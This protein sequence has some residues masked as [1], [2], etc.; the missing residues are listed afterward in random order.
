MLGYVRALVGI[1]RVAPGEDL[2]S[3]LIAIRDGE[4][5]LNEDE[6]TSMARLLLIAG[7]ETTV[8]LIGNGVFTLLHHP[9]QLA[10][11]HQEPTRIGE[12]VEEIVR[13]EPPGQTALPR[14]A[15]ER[16]E[17]AGVTTAPGDTVLVAATTAPSPFGRRWGRPLSADIIGEVAC[18]GPP[19][20]STRTT[21]DQP[22]QNNCGLL[23]PSGN[24]IS[25]GKSSTTA[26][27]RLITASKKHEPR[28]RPSKVSGRMSETTGRR[29][30]RPT[31]DRCHEA[32]ACRRST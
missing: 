24:R 6:L 15:A 1:K 19:T 2:L 11:L 26:T 4:D 30:P 29:S 18:G 14:Y 31:V 9:A 21:A 12:F 16:I 10:L 28:L 17:L 13:C 22:D 20:A 32:Q 7:H 27:K 25:T 8:N 23:P 3:A 5:K